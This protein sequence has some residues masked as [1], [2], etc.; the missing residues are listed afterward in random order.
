MWQIIRTK[1]ISK[2]LEEWIEY[3]NKIT[4]KEIWD[5]LK[6]IYSSGYSCGVNIQD[7]S[8][9]RFIIDLW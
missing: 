4:S 7:W 5:S 1:E 8:Q 9:L 3:E 2:K 6:N